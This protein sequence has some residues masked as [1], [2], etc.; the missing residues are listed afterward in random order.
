MYWI[1]NMMCP[2]ATLKLGAAVSLRQGFRAE[3]STGV[4]QCFC[5]FFITGH[6]CF[7]GN[8]KSATFFLAKKTEGPMGPDEAYR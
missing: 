2:M 3:Y 4:E 8:R 6:S 5:H 1:V 7:C